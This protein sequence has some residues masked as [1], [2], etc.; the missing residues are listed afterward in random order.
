VSGRQLDLFAGPPPPAPRELDFSEDA[1]LAARVPPHV[2]FGTSSWTFPGWSG[3]VYPPGTTD[4]ELKERGLELYARCPLFRTVGIDRSYYRPLAR[5]ELSRYAAELPPGFPCVMKVWTEVTSRVHPATRVP[6]PSFLSATVFE[7]AVL[8]PVT[9]AFGDH[10]GPFVLELAPMRGAELPRRGELPDLLSRFFES[11]PKGNRYAVELRNRELLTPRYLK[12][13]AAHGVA[14]VLNFWERMPSIGEQ[15][16]LPGVLTTTFVVARLLI[17]PGERYEEKKAEFAP[18]DR[19]VTPQPALYD[20]V[21]RLVEATLSRGAELFV[22][23]NNKVEGSSPL[24]VRGLARR[25]G[26]SDGGP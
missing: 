12:A 4:R 14:H 13:L 15:L 19:I 3:I 11:L 9:E 26:L 7:D 16:D 25:I 20:D 22:I 2:R 5:E 1:A 8:G 23:V 21:Q 6:N 17:A 24:T 18:F 10:A